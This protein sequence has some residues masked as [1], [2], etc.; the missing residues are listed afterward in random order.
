PT[1]KAR[2]GH[3]IL[4][5]WV[6][7]EVFK[8]LPAF[9]AN[10]L[11]SWLSIP[12]ATANDLV[13]LF[14]GNSS[15]SYQNFSKSKFALS[16]SLTLNCYTYHYGP[17]SPSKEDRQLFLC[18]IFA[19]AALRPNV[20]DLPVFTLLGSHILQ[21]LFNFAQKRPQYSFPNFRTALADK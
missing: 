14:F 9:G 11:L 7:D 1:F 15:Y 8:T 12:P 19:P 20:T 6:C 16:S 13:P 4:S 10:E 17:R 5:S 3:S 21:A 18:G 2:T